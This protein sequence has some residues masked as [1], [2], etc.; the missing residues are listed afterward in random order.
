MGGPPPPPPPLSPSADNNAS[1]TKK[2]L[3]RAAVDDYLR[4]HDVYGSIRRLVAT[5]EG[6]DG[7]DS[8]P[9][10]DEGTSETAT[11]VIE[12]VVRGLK[13]SKGGIHDEAQRSSS[14][15]STSS[16]K[17]NILRVRI[18]RGRAFGAASSN[19]HYVL[20]LSFGDQR[21]SSAPTPTCAEPEF[22][23]EFVIK[24]A[25]SSPDPDS[26]LK[27]PGT[28]LQFAL[29][30]VFP[31]IDG[32]KEL[33]AS[34]D[35][36]WR[37][38]LTKGSASVSIEMNG[39]GPT[40]KTRLAV[41]IIDIHIDLSRKSSAKLDV[42]SY[43]R[44][45]SAASAEAHRRFCKYARVWWQEYTAI[46][47]DFRTRLV[48]IFAENEWGEHVPSCTFLTPLKCGRLIRSPRHGARFVSLLPYLREEAVGGG[49]IESW[50]SL[51][52]FL[53]V[54]G[55]D[56]EDHA[57]LLCCIL[58]GFGMDAYV[59]VG[60][61]EDGKERRDH[62][63]VA[64]VSGAKNKYAT[65]WESLTGQRIE[66][67]HKNSSSSYLSIGCAFNHESFYANK[68]KDDRVAGCSFHFLDDRCWKGMDGR[69]LKALKH[70]RQVT[71]LPPKLDPSAVAQAIESALKGLIHSYRERNDAS[72]TS[73]DSDLSYMLTPALDAYENER[74]L[75]VSSDSNDFATIVRK[76]IP[77]G[78][79][80]KGYPLFATNRDPRQMLNALVSSPVASDILNT[81]S[82]DSTRFALRVSVF[83]YPENA[84]AIWVMLAVRFRAA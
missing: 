53:T 47:E 81:Q 20:H 18:L 33:V 26:L 72:R 36:E 46:R 27:S 42:K 31:G 63:W 5:R 39:P 14:F 29:V 22:G 13:E 8:D 35:L 78:H 59:C 84:H 68:Q 43:L 12:A 21:F 71:L 15:S 24:L 65:F 69:L 9:D 30:K 28:P 67:P 50:H 77:K 3:L 17:D 62:V 38:V 56:C 37:R 4:A 61:V 54:G 57:V 79:S 73:W 55:G 2:A 52:S 80:F 34:H 82:D 40:S 44:A 58:L 75:G 41:G 51:H 10:P 60:T 23:D 19:A 70:Q 64:T 48:K 32:A 1:T 6:V 83:A 25:G 11:S 45:E 16:S 49:R 74:V 76:Q 66:N 7:A